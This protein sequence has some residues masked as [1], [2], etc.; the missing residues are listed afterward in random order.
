MRRVG[1]DRSLARVYLSLYG[2]SCSYFC[3][4]PSNLHA[5][6]MSKSRGFLSLRFTLNRPVIFS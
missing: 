3:C 2:L 1:R 4:F 5:M 6:S